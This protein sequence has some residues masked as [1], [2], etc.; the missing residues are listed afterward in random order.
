[1]CLRLGVNY[2]DFNIFYRSLS[3]LELA[4]FSPS[5]EQIRKANSSSS[6]KSWNQYGLNAGLIQAD[7]SLSGITSRASIIFSLRLQLAEWNYNYNYTD[8]EVTITPLL[9]HVS[10]SHSQ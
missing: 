6:T 3:L 5:P 1:M 9:T 10:V 8:A 4:C 2:V 7:D